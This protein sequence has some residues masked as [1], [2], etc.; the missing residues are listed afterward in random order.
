MIKD[1]TEGKSMLKKVGKIVCL[2]TVTAVIAGGLVLG[3]ADK[4]HAAGAGEPAPKLQW[5]FDGMFGMYDRA[6]LQRGYQVYSQVCSACHSMNNVYYRNLETLGYDE[7]EIKAIASQYSVMDGPNDEGEMYER[8]ARPS[9][10]F[11]NPYPNK[12][13]A[14][15]ANNGAFPPDMS[16][17][18]FA[19]AGGADYIN[20]ILTGYEDAPHG[21]ELLPGQYWNKYMPGHVIAM[22]PPLSDGMIDY[23]DGSPQIVSQYARDVAHFL[24]WASDPHMEDRKKIGFQALAFLLIFAGVMYRVKKKV[25]AKLH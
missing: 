16:S 17:L 21:H 7:A 6:A 5:S 20:G 14:K 2:A 15:Y 13:A 22:A 4:A 11:V 19:R 8:T 24:A 9:D 10:R 1:K 18:A 23:S 12:Q 3:T 25:W